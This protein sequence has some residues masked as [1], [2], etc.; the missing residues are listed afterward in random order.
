ME[1]LWGAGNLCMSKTDFHSNS[2]ASAFWKRGILENIY[3]KPL[4]LYDLFF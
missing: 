3:R 4:W 2:F 1:N